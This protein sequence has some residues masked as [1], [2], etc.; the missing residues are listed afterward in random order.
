M[1]FPPAMQARLNRQNGI[2]AMLTSAQHAKT[3]ETLG[4]G[5]KWQVTPYQQG[6]FDKAGMVGL[7]AGRVVSSNDMQGYF[8]SFMGV[9]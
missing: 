1:N 4:F 6:L 8:D 5:N 7:T 9:A 3:N 2:L